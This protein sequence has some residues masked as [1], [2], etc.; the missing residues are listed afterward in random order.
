MEQT[1]KRHTV[2]LLFQNKGYIYNMMFTLIFAHYDM[3]DHWMGLGFGYII[4]RQVYCIRKL[5]N[6]MNIVGKVY[7]YNAQTRATQWDRPEGPDVK[8]LTQVCKVIEFSHTQ[9]FLT[10][11]TRFSYMQVHSQKS[12]SS[13]LCNKVS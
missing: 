2:A 11:S 7:Y 1:D 10:Q 12:F 6:V 8:V 9:T 4:Y 3:L 5:L 13:L